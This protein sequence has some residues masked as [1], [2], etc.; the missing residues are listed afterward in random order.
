MGPQPETGCAIAK[1]HFCFG[2]LEGCDENGSSPTFCAVRRKIYC[3]KDGGETATRNVVSDFKNMTV[4]AVKQW[5]ENKVGGSSPRSA[6]R[7][8]EVSFSF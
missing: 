6:Q 4:P 3:R 5:P 2:S 8:G 1:T 7:Y